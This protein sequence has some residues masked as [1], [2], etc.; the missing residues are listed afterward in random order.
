VTGEKILIIDDEIE[1][2]ETCAECLV[3]RGFDVRAISDLHAIMEAFTSAWRPALVL[4]D[5]HMPEINGLEVLALIKRFDP[6]IKVIIVTAYGSTEDGIEGM[7]QGVFDYLMK[8]VE[9]DELVAS[10]R[11]ALDSKSFPPGS[12]SSES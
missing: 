9:I 6:A 10:I 2:A 7:R 1:F 8:P 11:Q 12:G 3:L 5:L 4:L